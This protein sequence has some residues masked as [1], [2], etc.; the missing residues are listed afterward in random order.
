[1]IISNLYVRVMLLLIADRRLRAVSRITNRFIL[2]GK[3]PLMNRSIQL[4]LELPPGKSVRPTDRRNNTSP[5]NTS[6]L[7]L[8]K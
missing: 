6:S 7:F 2:H 3:K 5:L 1:M 4:S 8:S